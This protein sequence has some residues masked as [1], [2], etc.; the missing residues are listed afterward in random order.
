MDG[1]DALRCVRCGSTNIGHLRRRTTR[2]AA[3]WK[4]RCRQCGLVS[5]YVPTLRDIRAAC[6]RIRAEHLAW[7][8]A[9]DGPPAA[10]PQRRRAS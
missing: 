5:E 6:R 9:A 3:V 10:E 2:G 7:M 4:N 8:A 1:A